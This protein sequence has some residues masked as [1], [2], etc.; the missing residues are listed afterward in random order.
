LQESRKDGP[1]APFFVAAET[2]ANLEVNRWIRGGG[3]VIGF[4]C[5]AMPEELF[6]AAGLL[7]FRVRGTGS[8]ST[9]LA[10]TCFSSLNCSFARHCLN[11]ALE[12][13]YGF[14]DGLVMFNSCDAIRRTYDHWIRKVETPFVRL[15]HLPRKGEPPQLEFFRQELCTLRQDREKRFEVEIT[16]D[17]LRDAIRL[18]NQTRRLLRHLYELRRSEAPPITGAETLAVTVASTAMPKERFNDLLEDL[19][20]AL[21]DAKGASDYRARLLLLGSEIDD[22]HHLEIIEAEGGLVVA[23]SLCF[24][25]RLLWRDVDE[26]VED[27][28]EALARYCVADRPSCP[29]MCT[30]YD[31]RL[32]YLTHMVRD[33]DVDGV[34]LERIKFCDTWGFES[35]SLSHDFETL[36]IPL[37]VLER[38]Y[39]QSGSGQLRTRIQAF[40]E[41]L[42][43]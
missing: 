4:Y 3:R 12:G 37:L 13:E 23:D 1:F 18:H 43:G 16:D 11:L 32:E 35:Y 34:V 27:P 9:D 19:L 38:E 6:T 30:Q 24:G 41:M 10:D 42:E 28:M 36:E 15:L 26:G 39:N 14:L 17:G 40:L 21:R 31:S 8:T 29:R 2:L 25:S 20:I 33:F 5:A 22:P 7:P